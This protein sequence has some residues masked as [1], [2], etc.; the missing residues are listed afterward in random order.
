MS[1]DQTDVGKPHVSAPI[2]IEVSKR[3]LM[4]DQRRAF[5]FPIPQTPVAA[6]YSSTYIAFLQFV[7]AHCATR[8]ELDAVD[9]GFGRKCRH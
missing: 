9:A 1:F 8:A 4:S 2:C 3:F 5:A 7:N 6:F